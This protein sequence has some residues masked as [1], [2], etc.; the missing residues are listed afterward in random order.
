M[1]D[2]DDP[3]LKSIIEANETF[4]GANRKDA[5]TTMEIYQP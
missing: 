2:N 3:L 4:L 1:A 5:R